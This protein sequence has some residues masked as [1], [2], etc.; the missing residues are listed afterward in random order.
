MVDRYLWHS[1]SRP[2]NQRWP[3]VPA[4]REDELFSSWLIR[5][6]LCHA[7]GPLE[8][9]HMMWPGQR[10][11]TRDCDRRICTLPLDQLA[12][13]SGLEDGALLSSTLEPVCQLLHLDSSSRSITPWVLSLGS[14]NTRRAGGLQYCPACFNEP[15]PYYRLQWRLA[16]YTSCPFHRVLLRDRCPHCQAVISPHRLD[17]TALDLS[18]CHACRGRLSEVDLAP[19]DLKAC[20]LESFADSI[21]LGNELGFGG[22]VLPAHEWFALL[23]ELHQLLRALSRQRTEFAREF[24]SQLDVDLNALPEVVLG[25]PLEC[26]SIEDRV[27]YLSVLNDILQ[28]GARRFFLAARNPALSHSYYAAAIGDGQSCLRELLSDVPA[29]PYVRG[30][31]VFGKPRSKCSVLRSWLRFERKALRCGISR[32]CFLRWGNT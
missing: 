24:L 5:C 30:K 17:H 8:L 15:R 32:Q 7:C 28:A 27:A 20:E 22:L 10:L 25:L 23:R 4:L 6:S 26:L 9:A 1:G 29:R 13:N 31:R 16:W 12:Q 21:V 3:L 2:L 11:W 18:R 19:G 14:R